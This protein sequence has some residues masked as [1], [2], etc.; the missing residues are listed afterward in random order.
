[1]QRTQDQAWQ[2]FV[3]FVRLICLICF[4]FCLEMSGNTIW[5]ASRFSRIIKSTVDQLERELVSTSSST[6]HLHGQVVHDRIGMETN[7]WG[8]QT[9]TSG[10]S[11]ER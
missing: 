11:L 8:Y 5:K 4:D 3:H 2:D 1:M 6:P 7:N 10:P 9:K